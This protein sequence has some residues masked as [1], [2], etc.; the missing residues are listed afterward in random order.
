MYT[1]VHTCIHAGSDL[2]GVPAAW[3]SAAVASAAARTLRKFKPTT[4]RTSDSLQPL[5]INSAVRYGNCTRIH[6]CVCF[7]GGGDE[8]GDRGT[9]GYTG[10]KGRV[11]GWVIVS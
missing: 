2:V 1:H 6:E 9:G 3:S 10:E 4:L 11:M 7:R 8:T 5:V